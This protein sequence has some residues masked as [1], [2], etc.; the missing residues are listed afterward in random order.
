M[1]LADGYWSQHGTHTILLLAPVL[2]FAL[3]GFVADTR[4][5][6]RGRRLDPPVM[7][8]AAVAVIAAV[9]H[10]AVCPEH[11]AE[12]WL[13]GA[14]FTVTAG[15]QLLWAGLLVLRPG[16]RVVRAGLFASLGVVAL[17]AVTRTVGIPLGPEGGEV[18]TVG[19][20]DLLATTAELVA[21]AACVWVLGR[22]G[23]EDHG[24]AV[25]E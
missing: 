23:R 14:F 1:T 19:A 21:A 16:P 2:A 3:A 10:V 9:V 24:R 22:S 11:Y 18:E 7:L 5:W 15:T 17:W 8:A 20:L 6:L 25:A 4:A 13:Y 12:S